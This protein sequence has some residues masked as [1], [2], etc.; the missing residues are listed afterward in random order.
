MKKLLFV[1]ALV[2]VYALSVTHATAGITA[3]AKSKVT[4]VADDNKVTKDDSKKAEVKKEGEC[5]GKKV[6]GCCAGKTEGTGC[7]MSK[8]AGGCPHEKAG[9]VEKEAVP[10]QKK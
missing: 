3:S 1:L 4:I 5:T 10:A 6:E 9:T 8:Q 7:P 2:A